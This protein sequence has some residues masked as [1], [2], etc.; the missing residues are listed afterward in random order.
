MTE[1]ADVATPD[2]LPSRSPNL[3][4]ALTA[5]GF[6]AHLSGDGKLP[7]T[8]YYP[9]GEENGLYIE[10]VAQLQGSGYTRR[11]EPNDIVGVSSVT[12]QKL[13]HVDLLLFE[14]WDLELSAR[15]GFNVG[16]DTIVVRV[17]NPASYLFQK[18]L[19]LRKRKT[20]TKQ[21][22]DTLYIHDTLS[23]FGSS[24]DQLREQ[25]ARVL[26]RLANKTRREFHELRTA[27]FQDRALVVGAERTA[28]ATGRANPPSAGTIAAVCTA[29][30]ERILAP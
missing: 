23:M 14:P 30:L 17:A 13:R 19:T 12:A 26:D 6:K 11:G 24:F 18:V 1:D 21:S 20:P 15:R 5:A 22:K 2:R 29:G 16:A 3:D 28:A 25:A 10:F 9:E 7:V 27:L 4:E 8:K